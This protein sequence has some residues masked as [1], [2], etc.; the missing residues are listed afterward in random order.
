MDR[1]ELPEYYI[2]PKLIASLAARLQ[3]GAV[4]IIPTDTVYAL[5]C[6]PLNHA[7]V[8]RMCK[9]VG[10]KAN[11][12]LLSLLCSDFRQ[13][14]ACTA[15]ISQPLFRLLRDK[16]PGPYTFILKASA[17]VEKQFHNKRKT[18][19]VRIPDH[20]VLLRI[21]EEFGRPLMATSL[22]SDDHILDY[23]NDPDE[24]SLGMP[25]IAD[26]LVDSGPCGIEP[27]TVLDC[28]GEEPLL[29]RKGKGA[30]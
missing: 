12:A 17:A 20:P 2:D 21:L 26:I 11:T 5:A 24:I 3:A 16:L 25:D 27:S 23:A 14:T 4:V 15:P 7:A 1:I 30:W 19:G 29:I 18:I 10:K 13:I 9:L 6:D 22:H 8:E 28:S